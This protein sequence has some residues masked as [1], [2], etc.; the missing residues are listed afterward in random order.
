MITIPRVDEL[1]SLMRGVKD[2]CN[3]IREW[4][5]GD[6]IVVKSPQMQLVLGT[7]CQ[8]AKTDAI[9]L[10]QGESGTGKE[11]IAKAIH[12]WSHRAEHPFIIIDCTTLP[13]ALVESELFGHEKGAFTGA[14]VAKRGLFE[15]GEGGTIFLDEVGDMPLSA[16]VKLLRVLQEQIIRRVGGTTAIRIDVRILA[17]TNQDLKTLVRR[18][19]FREDLYYR[20]NGITITIPPLRERREDIPVLAS[21]FLKGFSHRVGREIEGISSEAMEILLRHP[22]PGNVRELEKTIERAVVLGCSEF[23]VPND[24]PASLFGGD[25]FKSSLPKERVT[26]AELEKAH[27]LA[28]LSMHQWNQT[29]VAEELGISRTTLWRKLKKY[30]IEVLS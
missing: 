15:E 14:L 7:A 23:I 28:A 25:D 5:N 29:K 11:V 24:L 9:A 12:A 10:I 27:I 20:L 8:L 30:D 3:Q 17:A 26:L 1:K 2:L 4:Y 18:K 6:A 19:A 13:E 21:H 16:Q 22:W